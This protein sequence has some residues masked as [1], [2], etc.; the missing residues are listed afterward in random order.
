MKTNTIEI[1]EKFAAELARL[2]ESGRFI[3][4]VKVGLASG[5]VLTNRVVFNTTVLHLEEGEDF[6]P[7]E[8][9]HIELD[10][11]VH[12]SDMRF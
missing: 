2:P 10:A 1:P 3:H 9:T 5:E 7:E 8:I 12:S 6:A 4:K 11:P